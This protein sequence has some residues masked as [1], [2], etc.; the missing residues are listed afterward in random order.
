MLRIVPGTRERTFN[1]A[2][3]HIFVIVRCLY[4]IFSRSSTIFRL[5]PGDHTPLPSPL[6]KVADTERGRG[7]KEHFLVTRRAQVCSVTIYNA[8][9]ANV[10]KGWKYIFSHNLSQYGCRGAHSP[11]K[12]AFSLGQKP[13]CCK[14]QAKA[15]LSAPYQEC[16]RK[17]CMF[18]TH[19]SNR[20][21]HSP[22]PPLPSPS[23]VWE[24]ECMPCGR[25]WR[26]RPWDFDGRIE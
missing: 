19:P 26:G 10:L 6:T 1:I 11:D 9:E 8:K 4:I 18:T 15:T 22:I 24:V 3:Y 21:F 5:T 17:H 14:E 25:M 7:L 2:I 13:V 12:S 20:K 16:S 23:C